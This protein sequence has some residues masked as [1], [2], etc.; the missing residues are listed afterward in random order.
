MKCEKC[1]CKKEVVHR[2]KVDIPHRRQN[3]HHK[4][5]QQ[6]RNRR[7]AADIAGERSWLKLLR[8]SHADLETRNKIAITPDK[9]PPGLGL[10]LFGGRECARGKVDR[11][12]IR[13]HRQFEIARLCDIV[14]QIVTPAI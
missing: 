9:L 3:E 11:L 12:K 4:K 2:M 13:I 1:S 5:E 14:A 6:Q 10:P 7:E 8:H